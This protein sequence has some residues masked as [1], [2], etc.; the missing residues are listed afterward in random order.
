MNVCLTKLINFNLCE[1]EE[2]YLEAQVESLEDLVAFLGE[3][4]SVE[5]LEVPFVAAF[6]EAALVVGWEH[7]RPLLVLIDLEVLP[8]A[9]LPDS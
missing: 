8:L 7:R 9:E 1:V 3:V 2:A 5:P 4:P 6:L